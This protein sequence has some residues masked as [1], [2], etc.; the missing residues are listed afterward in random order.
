MLVT[1]GINVLSILRSLL[2]Q[3]RNALELLGVAQDPE[4]VLILGGV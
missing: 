2:A 3:L 1:V 4:V